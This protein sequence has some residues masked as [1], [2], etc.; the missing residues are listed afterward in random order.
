M[1]NLIDGVGFMTMLSSGAR[2]LDSNRKIINDL[3]VFP[4]PDGDTGDNMYMTISAGCERASAEKSYNLSDVAKLA[5]SGML[6]G[7]RGNSGVILSRIFAGLSKGLAG[8][9][10]ADANAFVNAL[11]CAVTEAYASVS[12]PVE[13]TILTVLKD[14]V[15]FCSK[16][17]YT[18]FEKV[19][20]DL[21][22]EMRAALDRT[23]DLLAVLKEAGVVDSGGAGL[24]VIAE[25]FL[26]ALK[27]GL[28]PVEDDFSSLSANGSGKVQKVNL[29]DFGPDS[30]LE[31][32]YCT[33]FLLRLQR[34]KVGD[35]SAFDESQIREYLT[36]N[37]ESVVCFKDDSIVKVH[38]HTKTPGDILS[39]CQ[40]WG[41]FLTVK[42]E[43]MSLQ[44]EATTIQDNFSS[45]KAEAPEKESFVRRKRYAVVTVAAGDGLVETFREAGADFVIEGGQTM[46]PSAQ[47]FIAAFDEVNAETILVFPN[48]SNIVMTAQ[49]A[50]GM[51]K[52]SR[53]V[54]LPCKTIGG[55]YVAIASL[56][57][58]CNDVD[59]IV[60]S[61]CEVLDNVVSGSVSVA[62]RDT[63][64]NGV[65]V[66]KGDYIGFERSRVLVAEKSKNEAAV[67]LTGKLNIQDHE[68]ALFFRGADTSEEEANALAADLQSKFPR[69]E[70][71]MNNGGQPV[72]DYIL[73]LC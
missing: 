35:P 2:R 7:A 39:H 4:I 32:G 60:A 21:V 70:I 45:E 53:V 44:H 58:S 46:N 47:D 52:K 71:I 49:Q 62:I 23:P 63:Q 17:R 18:D 33:E 1:I 36:A 19:Q 25:G 56:D 50:A 37:G 43:N 38:V 30:V 6:F 59:T 69:T 9:E 8:L 48:N 29:D 51:Y 41:E 73:I 67:S 5:S 16:N 42:V 65:S 54:V 66:T 13:G 26:D 57:T 28:Q 24:L 10:K 27:K 20:N 14:S 40:R 34:A 22:E 64:Q 3:N 11:Q 31:F 68:V 15:T 61:T 12:T 55:G 72:F